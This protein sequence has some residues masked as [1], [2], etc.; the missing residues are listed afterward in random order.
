MHNIILLGKK[1]TQED[2][3]SK[4]ASGVASGTAASALM[5]GHLEGFIVH[6][7]VALSSRV[8]TAS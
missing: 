3:G 1:K 5:C 2:G 6:S 4:A 7:Y 8:K